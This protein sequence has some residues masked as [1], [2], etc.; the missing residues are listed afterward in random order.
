[1]YIYLYRIYLVTQRNYDYC[2]AAINGYCHRHAFA[3]TSDL[4]DETP[5]GQTTACF[6]YRLNAW[7]A[8][9]GCG[10]CMYIH[11]YLAAQHTHKRHIA[12]TE[13]SS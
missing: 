9:Y 7:D 1:M 12:S 11:A 8:M 10:N 6:L 13:Q 5:D 3:G 2:R 4:C